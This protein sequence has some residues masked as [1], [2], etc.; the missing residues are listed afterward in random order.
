[1]AEKWKL[2]GTLFDACNCTTLCPCN[3]A[4]V[5]TNP[6]DC[7]AVAIWHVN[8]GNYGQTSLNGLN[9]A[10]AI[11]SAGNPLTQGV[12]R[13]AMVLDEAASPQQRQALGVI[14]GGQAGGLFAMLGPTVKQNLGATFARFTYS[15]DEK[16]WSVKAGNGLEVTGGFLKP[17]PGMPLEVRPLRVQTMD[18]LFSPTM[19]KIVGI[20]DKVKVNAAGI[21]LDFSGKYSS[22]GKFAY[23]GG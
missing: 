3:F 8:Q 5:P 11:A 16:T 9:F 2:S 6:K 12:D 4:Q 18:P 14:L 1:M 7:R 17:P 22:A 10:M 19:E 23:E 13:A 15:N 20:S 21:V